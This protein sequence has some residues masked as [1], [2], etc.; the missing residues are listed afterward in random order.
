MFK[1]VESYE[2]AMMI[3]DPLFSC[4]WMLG[5]AEGVR[6]GPGAKVKS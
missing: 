5:A 4:G 3:N 2:T 1:L 6:L